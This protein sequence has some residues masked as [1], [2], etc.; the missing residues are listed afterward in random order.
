[1]MLQNIY[2]LIIDSNAE[3]FNR[4]KAILEENPLVTGIDWALNSDD[5]LLKVIR[6]NP[7]II[8]ME[9]PQK[10]QS[11]KELL[12]FIKTN[13]TKSMLV[14]ISGTRKNAVNAIRDEIFN[15]IVRPIS[16]DKLENVINKF[17]LLR[18][19]NT[20]N[21]I[22]EIIEKTVEEKQILL[23]TSKGYMLIY[24]EEIVYCKADGVI[25][26]M[27]LTNNRMELCYSFLSKLEQLLTPYNFMRISRSA[28]V[29]TKYIRRANRKNNTII[30]SV[31]GTEYEVKASKISVRNLI[32][33]IFE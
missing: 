29:N 2:V 19:N 3:S 6:D 21:R 11:G 12:K 22:D 33:S 20:Q 5:A 31:D 4:T 23:Q 1:M 18:Q 16:I 26:E 10:G 30:L 25:S 14:L 7:D 13:L 9:Y 17:Q 27:Y 28:L 15:F 8:L 24:P 32:N